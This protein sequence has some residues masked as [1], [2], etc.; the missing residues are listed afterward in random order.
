MVKIGR[1]DPCPCGSGKK[2]KNCCAGKPFPMANKAVGYMLDQQHGQLVVYTDE[3]LINQLQRDSLKIA[4]SF[5]ELCEEHLRSMSRLCSEVFMLLHQGLIVDLYHNE[6]DQACIGMLMNAAN[7]FSAA[8][9]LLRNGY[10][11]PPGILVRNILETI[12]TVLHLFTRPDDLK[13]F[14]EGQLKSSKT[15]AAA[16]EVLPPFG[17]L[18]GFFS[19]EFA[20]IGSIQR[21]L[22]PLVPYDHIDD[23]LRVNLCFLKMTIW[24]LYV[25]SE[26]LCLDIVGR[27]RYWHCLGKKQDGQTAYA[28]APSTEE[29]RWMA[30]FLGDC[31]ALED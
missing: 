19:Q 14:K 26:L 13:K 30:R 16:K 20:H 29:R 11:L 6:L 25:S 22:Q 9:T 23:A 4:A 3:M 15:I 27:P 1:N 24:L 2:Y 5:D 10:R 12:S 7:S 18:Y 31:G 21:E 17:R 8:V 28:Y